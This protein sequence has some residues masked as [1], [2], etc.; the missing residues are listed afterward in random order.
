[1]IFICR[2]KE[3]IDTQWNVNSDIIEV[4]P[5]DDEEL[6]DTQWNVNL[7][8]VDNELNVVEN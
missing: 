3:L 4:I 1:M 6:I 8:A 7:F 2:L 5:T